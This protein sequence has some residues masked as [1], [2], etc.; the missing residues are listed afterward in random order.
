MRWF[1]SEVITTAIVGITR[2]KATDG[3]GETMGPVP[4]N[5][6]RVKSEERVAKRDD[7]RRK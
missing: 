2:V 1:T 5:S 4:F 7:R 3:G 6:Q